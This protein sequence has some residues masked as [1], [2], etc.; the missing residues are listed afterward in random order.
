MKLEFLG[1]GGAIS[2]PK[3]LC[4]CTVCAEARTRGIPYARSGPSIFVH[5]PDVLIDTPEESKEQINRS[6]ITDIQ[7][8]LYSHWHPDHVMGRRVWEMNHDWRNWPPKDKCT[9]IWLPQQVAADFRTW[10]IMPQLEYLQSIRLI[11]IHELTDGEQIQVHGVTIT[12]I[13]LA[14]DYVYAFLF[15]DGQRSA[16]IVMDETFRWVPPSDL[17]GLDLVVLPMG[18]VDV[19]PRTGARRI[20]VDHP[21]LKAEATF[22]DTVKLAIEL[23]AKR[24]IL[25]HV[26]E[27]DGFGHDELQTLAREFSVKIPN[28]SVA[29]DGLIVEV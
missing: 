29:W 23:G 17:K 20:P 2:T 7:G 5:G 18:V 1:T 25:S 12:P 10:G 14:E 15:N 8:C 28:L 26:E 13:R 24:T 27:P 11:A 16:L 9:T 22:N 3:P 21:V 19:D 6:Q 4:S